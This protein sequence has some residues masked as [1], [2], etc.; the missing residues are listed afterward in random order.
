TH[1]PFTFREH[2]FAMLQVRRLI[3]PAIVEAVV[4]LSNSE[5]REQ[6]DLLRE[7]LRVISG[8]AQRKQRRSRIEVYRRGVELKTRLK[9]TNIKPHDSADSLQDRDLEYEAHPLAPA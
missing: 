5:R 9:L 4:I 8:R 2:Q 7:L 1:Q 6:S 3:Q